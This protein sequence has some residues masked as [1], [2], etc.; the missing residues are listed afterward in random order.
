MDQYQELLKKEREEKEMYK[1]RLEKKLDAIE[2]KN[3]NLHSKV[4]SELKK[5]TETLKRKQ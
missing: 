5:L 4:K 2:S 3:K 1:T